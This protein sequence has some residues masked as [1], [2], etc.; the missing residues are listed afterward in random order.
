MQLNSSDHRIYQ[1]LGLPFRLMGFTIDEFSTGSF[2]LWLS[3]RAE[4]L[5]LQV[6]YLFLSISGVYLLKKGKKLLSGFSAP[7]FI[8]WH[9]G[10]LR[11]ASCCWPRSCNR[12]WL[13]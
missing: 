3:A 9:F 11:N 2:F 7:S 6:L 8:H 12:F 4:T 13:S 5:W 10:I 1:H